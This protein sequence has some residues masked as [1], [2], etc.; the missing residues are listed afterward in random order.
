MAVTTGLE[1]AKTAKGDQA[2]LKRDD[3]SLHWSVLARLLDDLEKGP[4]WLGGWLAQ[5]KL[6]LHF[7]SFPG[8]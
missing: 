6:G 1:P 7:G 3:L 2:G 8:L 4:G 5:R